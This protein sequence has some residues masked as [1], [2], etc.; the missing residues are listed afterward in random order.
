MS[1]ALQGE[2]YCK[3]HQGNHAHYESTNCS[4]CN[5]RA[6]VVQLREGITKVQ[7]AAVHGMYGA[8]S[9]DCDPFEDALSELYALVTDKWIDIEDEGLPNFKIYGFQTGKKIKFRAGDG[10]HLGIYQGWGVFADENKL[11]T[12]DL[13]DVGFIGDKKVTHWREVI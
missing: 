7:N 10:E 12:T 9:V 6:E 11:S 2:H 4:V 8:D 5:L 3:V 13:Y 1:S